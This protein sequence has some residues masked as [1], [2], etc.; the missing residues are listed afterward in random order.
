MRIPFQRTLDDVFRSDRSIWLKI[1]G[2]VLVALYVTFQSILR[3]GKVADRSIVWRVSIIS[4]LV[5]V[6]CGGLIS[7][8]LTMKDRMKQRL[9][10]GERVNPLL[11]AYLC[12]GFWS[13]LLWCPTIFFF[14]IVLIIVT[15]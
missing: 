4:L 5:A 12:M 9:A 1:G 6:A 15:H 3:Q 2:G 11:R 13:L 14:G 10:K 7:F 8:L